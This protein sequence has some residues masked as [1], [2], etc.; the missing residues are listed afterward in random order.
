[1][2]LSG[3]SYSQARD[4][5]LLRSSHDATRS[6]LDVLGIRRRPTVRAQCTRLSA[7]PPPQPQPPAWPTGQV[8]PEN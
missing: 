2:T 3:T 6:A 1:V 4:H 8:V 5:A 7:L